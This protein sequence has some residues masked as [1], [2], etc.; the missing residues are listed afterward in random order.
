MPA[1]QTLLSR[2]VVTPVTM[3]L[4]LVSTV[5]GIMLLLHWQ[6]GLVRFS[7]EWLSLGFA[8]I[9]L[10]HLARNRGAFRAYFRRNATLVAVTA[11]LLLSLGVTGLTGT[12]GGASPRAVF[13][14]LSGATLASAA[15][16]LGPTVDA[17][18][19]RLA[20]VDIRASADQTL[21]EIAAA[22][23]RSVPGARHQRAPRPTGSDRENAGVQAP[24]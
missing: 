2:Q 17:A 1:L 23:E 21:R 24:S 12:T 13:Q 6:A 11:T 10:W 14:A 15:P 4:F 7:H 16:A 22:A 9:A 3:V 20:A 5:T 18:V 8:L 19:A